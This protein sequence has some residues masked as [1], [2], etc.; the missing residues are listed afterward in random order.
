MNF[1]FWILDSRFYP[2]VSAWIGIRQVIVAA[3][4]VVGGTI[5]FG[6]A[7][8]R[9]SPVV[10]A[11]FNTAREQYLAA[12]KFESETLVGPTAE[13]RSERLAW[14]IAGYQMVLDHFPDDQLYRPLAHLGIANC[15]FDMREYRKAIRIFEAIEARYP[16][17]P[18]AHAQAEWKIGRSY[19]ALGNPA[20]AKSH[21]KRCIDT[22]R[23]SENDLLKTIVAACMHLYVP[24]SVPSRTPGR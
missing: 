18:F 22:F 17:Y 4:A 11:Q 24:P 20:A 3:L 14:I 7:S 13:K 8:A 16:N 23:Y 12:Q 10:F 9:K 21:Y 2:S 5:A 1:R 15:Y 19:D 6:C